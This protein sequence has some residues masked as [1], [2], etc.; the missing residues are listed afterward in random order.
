MTGFT[1]AIIGALAVLVGQCF[2]VL[3]ILL[4]V[5]LNK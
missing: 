3:C 2:G 5:K 1:Y 4:W